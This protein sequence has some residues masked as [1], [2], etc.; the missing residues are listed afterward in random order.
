MTLHICMHTYLWNKDSTT[1]STSA[2]TTV[3]SA[4]KGLKQITAR[5][6]YTRVQVSLSNPNR[7][8]Q[9]RHAFL[10]TADEGQKDCSLGRGLPCATNTLPWWGSRS[11]I[12]LPPETILLA[13]GG[14][15]TGHT[16]RFNS[17]QAKQESGS[18]L[19]NEADWELSKMGLCQA[20]GCALTSKAPINFFMSGQKHLW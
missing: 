20:K 15:G 5:N 19:H 4:K 2:G 8:A 17:S 12:N 16:E 3:S 1:P 14:T 13:M 18:S 11:P 9:L 10:T 7:Y 6:P